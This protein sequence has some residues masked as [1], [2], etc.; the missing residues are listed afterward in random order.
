MVQIWWAGYLSDTS[1]SGWSKIHKVDEHEELNAIYPG[2]WGFCL[3]GHDPSLTNKTTAK[4][5]QEANVY[6]WGTNKES[7]LSL[8]DHQKPD[9]NHP[10]NKDT[11]MI[12]LGTNVKTAAA[13]FS[14][15]ALC[16][17]DNTIAIVD[18]NS[19]Y[20]QT[21]QPEL[22]NIGSTSYTPSTLCNTI[23]LLSKTIS[24][25]MPVASIAVGTEHM[26]L[27]TEAGSVYS[28]GQT[29]Q[30]QVGITAQKDTSPG[31]IAE[32]PKEGAQKLNHAI[33]NNTDKQ[34]Q[35]PILVLGPGMEDESLYYKDRTLQKRVVCIAVGAS[36]SLAV[37]EEGR[38][39]A[40]G[41]NKYGQC[42][43][44]EWGSTVLQPTIVE[45]LG[46]L[47]IIVVAGGQG[48]SL[49]LTD[50]GDV[51]AWGLSDCKQTLG[52]R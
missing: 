10:N 14:T 50:S 24:L 9:N 40:W 1:S 13:G 6:I 15:C 45:A 47:K 12:L 32:S 38:C 43:N 46:P 18:S 29:T 30:E 41:S 4:E 26:L 3:G 23:L 5:Q 33:F 35:Q 52:K 51:Y 25:P 34:Q 49:C 11:D 48:H 20:H 37:T 7:I 2:G 17:A 44:G 27:L 28:W 22:H 42:G 39:V 21:Q 31:F 16:L 8:D 19:T 36:H